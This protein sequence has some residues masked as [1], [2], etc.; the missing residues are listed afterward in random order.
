MSKDLGPTEIPRVNRGVGKGPLYGAWV[1][2]GV[3]G[4]GRPG[5]LAIGLT[6][7]DP[8]AFETGVATCTPVGGFKK[9]NAPTQKVGTGHDV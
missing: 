7:G 5:W 1:P 3:G 8:E 6:P 4:R 2:P 9:L